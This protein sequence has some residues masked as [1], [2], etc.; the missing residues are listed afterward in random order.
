[1][2]LIKV[3][4]L[5]KTHRRPITCIRILLIYWVFLFIATHT[6]VFE[7][8]VTKGKMNMLVS[9]IVMVYRL[10]SMALVPGLL[11]L[12]IF[13]VLKPATDRKKV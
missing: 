5:I 8:G 11:I 4:E 6:T 1:M 2:E 9:V 10:L 7:Y 3:K 12:W 13:E